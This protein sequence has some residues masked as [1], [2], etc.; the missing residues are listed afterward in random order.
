MAKEQVSTVL[1]ALDILE[2]FMDHS[3][4]W[5]L[6]G[7]TEHLGLPTTTVYRQLTTLAEKQYLRHPGLNDY[8]RLIPSLTPK[9]R[10]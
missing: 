5:T 8:R 2:C 9:E 7:I 1:R 3:T 6:K 10:R 4:E